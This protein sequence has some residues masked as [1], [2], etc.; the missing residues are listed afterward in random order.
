MHT[1]HAYIQCIHSCRRLRL[2]GALRSPRS[3]AQREVSQSAERD[4]R[5]GQGTKKSLKYNKLEIVLYCTVSIQDGA[6]IT[7]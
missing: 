4:P 7:M 5:G 2:Q 1:M 6:Y 3:C